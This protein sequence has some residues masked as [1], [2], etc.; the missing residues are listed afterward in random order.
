VAGDFYQTNQFAD[1]EDH[2]VSVFSASRT[3]AI[4]KSY[5]D[6]KGETKRAKQY[7]DTMLPEEHW[8]GQKDLARPIWGKETQQPVWLRHMTDALLERRVPREQ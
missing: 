3:A 7:L 1:M 8:E 4:T 6:L 2:N 5:G